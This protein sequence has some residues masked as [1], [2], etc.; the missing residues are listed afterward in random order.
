LAVNHQTIPRGEKDWYMLCNKSTEFMLENGIERDTINYLIVEHIIDELNLKE[1]L[2]ILNVFYENPEKIDKYNNENLFKHIKM[3]IHSKIIIGK[4]RIK[5]FLW[6]DKSIQVILVKQHVREDTETD[7][8]MN[9]KWYIAESEDEKDLKEVIEMKKLNIMKNLNNTIGFMI[10]FK[11]DDNVV[12][13]T[14]D[15]LNERDL[16]ARCDQKSDKNKEVDLL[17]SIIG[18]KIFT[19][20]TDISLRGI[21]II[22]ELYLR[23]FERDRNKEKHWFL[24][25]AESLLTSI[26]K[27]VKKTKGKGKGNVVGKK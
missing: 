10:N 5:G 13:K 23:L 2:M 25:S 21:C 27:K 18:K 20:D 7:N 15:T 6:K 11:N 26:D 1:M 12:F 17:N 9:K 8:K 22:Q 19:I 16:G 24:T 4:R 14:K 3:Y